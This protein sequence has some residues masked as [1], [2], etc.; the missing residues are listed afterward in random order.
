MS[1]CP[2]ATRCWNRR[3]LNKHRQIMVR[4]S[5]PAGVTMPSDGRSPGRWRRPVKLVTQCFQQTCHRNIRRAIHTDRHLCIKVHK[6]EGLINLIVN[7][8]QVKFVMLSDTFP[9]FNTEP[10]SGST[11]SADRLLNRHIN[12]IPA[13]A[14][15]AVPDSLALTWPEATAASRDMLNALQAI[16]PAAH[17]RQ[18][19]YHF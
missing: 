16:S 14:P 17:W 2:T 5:G 8:R 6:A 12:D 1:L 15:L 7:Q 19:L 3:K 11:P 18:H 9:V 13:T 4:S 10:P